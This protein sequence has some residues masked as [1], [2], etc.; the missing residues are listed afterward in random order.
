MSNSWIMS[1]L[2]IALAAVLAGGCAAVNELAQSS[3][4]R[5]GVDDARITGIDFNGVEL[6]FDVGV[7]NPNPFSAS[8]AGFDYDFKLANTTLV[9]GQNPGG[10]SVEA[11]GK[12]TV[13]I[14]VAMEFADIYRQLRSLSNADNAPYQLIGGLTFDLPVVGR[15][16]LPLSK[17]GELPM[18]KLPE[19]SVSSFRVA[20][21]GLTGA[22]LALDLNVQNPNA[23]A[24]GLKALSY[25][26]TVDGRPWATGVANQLGTVDAKSAGVVSL[27]IELS[28]AQTGMAVYQL[29]RGDAPLDY[30]FAGDMQLSTTHE[31]LRDVAVPF[32][33]QQ[34]APLT[35]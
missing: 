25:A 34:L 15:T 31:M 18:L 5:I 28:F 12:S 30:A 4:P 35:R 3:T 33:A 8:V 16:R 19:I 14:P 32:A 7:H 9:A 11:M 20:D 17:S 2:T 6:E 21:L 27:P 22:R 29:L 23:F 26:L 10:M 1:V 13:V 24:F